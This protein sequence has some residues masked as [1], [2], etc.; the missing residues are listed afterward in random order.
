MSNLGA[1]PDERE[2]VQG[3]GEF[4]YAC[5]CGKRNS[6]FELVDNGDVRCFVC[7]VVMID[8]SV[9]FPKGI[10]HVYED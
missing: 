1:D 9:N 4:I 7:D 5:P 6:V 2:L 10:K 8:I 3:T